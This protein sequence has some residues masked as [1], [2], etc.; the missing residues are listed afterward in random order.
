MLGAA[1]I[2]LALQT[3]AAVAAPYA[4][5]PTEPASHPDWLRRPSGDVFGR[6]Y[7]LKAAKYGVAGSVMLTCVVDNDGF[8]NNCQVR[9]ES[10]LGFGFGQAAIMLSRTMVMTPGY[11]GW[12][13]IPVNWTAVHG[14]YRTTGSDLGHITRPLFLSAP[15]PDE[16][17]AAYP[18]D[19]GGVNGYAVLN[20]DVLRYNGRFGRCTSVFEQ[21]PGRGFGAAAVSLASKF[22]IKVP[23][24]E[25]REALAIWLEFPVRL[26][27]PHA[28]ETTTLE[29]ADP[30]WL[31]EPGPADAEAPGGAAS[32][33][34]A[35]CAAHRGGAL[36]DCQAIGRPNA[37]LSDAAAKAAAK[38]QMS[39]WTADGQPVEG[40]NVFVRVM[41]GPD[42]PRTKDDHSPASPR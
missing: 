16:V 14:M 33:G 37:K 39:V 31:T 42:T 6:T 12:V 36:S 29:I 30:V 20:C 21:P 26:P 38:M 13:N 22:E 24:L 8:L 10:P 15:S 41:F 19:G 28:S 17:E 9:K 2:L 34:F 7:P 1:L 40:A 11:K 35:Y 32:F 3:T 5:Q 23:D 27:A 25:K 4:T 18:K